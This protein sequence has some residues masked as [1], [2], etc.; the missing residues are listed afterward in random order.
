[1]VVR[2]FGYMGWMGNSGWIRVVR[3][4]F[5]IFRAEC[6]ELLTLINAGDAHGRTSGVR[7]ISPTDVG[8]LLSAS[9]GLYIMLILA[10]ILDDLFMITIPYAIPVYFVLLT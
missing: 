3:T 8:N 1:M 7:S 2:E 4:F 10:S 6:S 5:V 9:G